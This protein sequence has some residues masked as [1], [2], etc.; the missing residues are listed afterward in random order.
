MPA[1]TR[2]QAV[3]VTGGHLRQQ[4]RVRSA[5][6]RVDDLWKSD[7]LWDLVAKRPWLPGPT[8]SWMSGTA[9][10]QK[11]RRT[12]P[13]DNDYA[14]AS[15]GKSKLGLGVIRVRGRTNADTTACQV[16]RINWANVTNV[17]SMVNTLAHENTHILGRG[18]AGIN[19]C[20]GGP[21]V[22]TWFFTDGDY[23]EQT[24]PWLVSYAFGDLAQCFSDEDG[25]AEDVLTCFEQRIDGT[26]GF[27]RPYEE[28]CLDSA[29]A[30]VLAVRKESGR[31]TPA[32][33]ESREKACP[34]RE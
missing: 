22:R 13:I 6:V 27:C 26:D 21:E 2:E 1:T 5:A 16:A 3:K 28:C 17:S 15:L 12:R 11:L 23:T 33:C 19:D 18:S 14:M 7:A 8:E 10:A 34:A 25:V 29:P 30:N 31:C 20:D 4:A 9:V 24:K 32:M